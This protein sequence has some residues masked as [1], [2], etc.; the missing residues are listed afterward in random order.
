ME[1]GLNGE[2]GDRILSLSIEKDGRS[3]ILL[4]RLWIAVTVEEALLEADGWDCFDGE[5]FGGRSL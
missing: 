3:P 2:G 4:V 5:G 1:G